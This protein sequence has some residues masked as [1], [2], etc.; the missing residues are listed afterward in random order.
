[1]RLLL[2][3]WIAACSPTPR[4]VGIEDVDQAAVMGRTNVLCRGLEMPD[5]AVRKFAAEKLWPHPDPDLK[6]CL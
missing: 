6:A 2:P 3:L 1:M 5:D 4:T